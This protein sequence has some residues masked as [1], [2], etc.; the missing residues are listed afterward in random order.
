MAATS[1]PIA[2]TP[3]VVVGATLQV[4]QTK[5]REWPLEVEKVP[6]PFWDTGVF[7]TE[8]ANLNKLPM[9]FEHL[10][11][12]EKA[13]AHQN[14][15][16][17]FQK[18]QDNAPEAIS[19]GTYR[20]TQLALTKVYQLIEKSYESF[21]D[22]AN[23]EPSIPSPL[24]LEQ[25]RKIFSFTDPAT[26]GYPPHLNLAANKSFAE[27]KA[28]P[29]Q[30]STLT[31]GDLFNK[32]RLAQLTALLPQLVPKTFLGRTAAGAGQL[33][34]ELALGDMGRPD[35]GQTLA[36]VEEYNKKQRAK[37]GSFFQ[38]ND[39]FNLPN[40][41]DISDWWSDRRF[42]QQFFTGPN[43]TTIEPASDFWV[44]HFIDDATNAPE[45]Q[46]MK[47]KIQDLA[48]K[49]RGSLYMQ[50]YSYFR[51]A[52]GLKDSDEMKCE[53]QET[54]KSGLGTKT[55]T[56][57]RYGVAAVCLFHL[58]E[59]GVL[60]PL[61][62]VC[63]WRGSADKSVTIYNKELAQSKQKEDWPWRYAKTCVQTSDW[64]RHE[65]VVHLVNTHFIEEATIVGA[66]QAFEDHH[67]V[68]QLLYPH[69][70][71]TLSINAGAR[72]SLVPNV[73]VDLIGVT[74]DQAKT[75]IMHEYKNFDFKGRY[76]PLDLK[77][78]GFPTEKRDD[79]KYINYAYARCIYSM[80]FKIHSFVTEMLAIHYGK[81]GQKKDKA[82]QA[83]QHV[84][85]WCTYM[86]SPSAPKDGGAD[87][88]S[89]P[90]ITNFAELVD[91]VT[92]CIHL[93]SPQHTAVN[94]LQNYYQSFVVNKPPCL[95]RPIA[96]SRQELDSYKE[97]DLVIALPMNRPREWLLAS[98]IPY[99]LSAKP[100]D[101][102]S[103]IIYA[104]SKYH[105]YK[106]K[107]GPGEQEIKQAAAKFYKAL[108]D[109]EE[110]FKK[111][112]Q[113]TWD[114]DSIQYNVLSP[115]WNAVSIVI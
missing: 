53:F 7:V 84:K 13:A 93:A 56:S 37:S 39:I 57:H 68:F 11:E 97:Q 33:V 61:A 80:W 65:V 47:K 50:D 83:D 51:K 5:E 88:P 23:F 3:G 26:D 67:P 96:E 36:D 81:D 41:G 59:N 22:T 82:V 101:K 94:Y 15:E 35:E 106:A 30:K 29:M 91:A 8:L 63:D 58:P 113:D 2:L 72:A 14:P 70:Q 71:K 21:M 78:R 112:G 92:M 1:Q 73:I 19:E 18:A 62:I 38:R 100:G 69:W 110:E 104:A 4:N 17:L 9:K 32:M 109:S 10:T 66:Q 54:Y 107:T 25:K 111:F 52:C 27:D 98:H 85:N 64:M 40:I 31:Q 89:F 46:K 87:L 34:A 6:I 114:S 77:R 49:D 43:P 99:L 42:A 16:A 79:P 76:V 60:Q 86:Q 24:S 20:G 102:E 115:S 45:D 103:L 74:A 105:L 90:T 75:F 12:E 95:Y 28:A 55:K 44:K 48:S 108:A